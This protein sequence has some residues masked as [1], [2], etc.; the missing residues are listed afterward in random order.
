VL[1]GAGR[2]KKLTGSRQARSFSALVPFRLAYLGRSLRAC[3][4]LRT[5]TVIATPGLTPKTFWSR[6]ARAVRVL[7]PSDTTDRELKVVA[8]LR[9]IPR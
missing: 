2:G 1:S 3:F 8:R 7:P 9:R 4:G 5:P 6:D